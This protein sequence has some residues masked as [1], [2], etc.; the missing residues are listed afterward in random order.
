MRNAGTRDTH[1]RPRARERRDDSSLP[2]GIRTRPVT[3]DVVAY[4]RDQPHIRARSTN[5]QT[6]TTTR[7]LLGSIALHARH[8]PSSF[9]MCGG[10]A[11]ETPNI[12][13]EPTPPASARASLRLLARLTAGVRHEFHRSGKEVRQQQWSLATQQFPERDKTL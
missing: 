4:S 9:H 8:G 5:D 7:G 13:L 10:V 12:A 11:A 2:N 3:S 1:E 6:V